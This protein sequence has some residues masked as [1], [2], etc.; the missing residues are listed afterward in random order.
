MATGVANKEII[1]IENTPEN[2]DTYCSHGSLA[3]LIPQIIKK[4]CYAAEQSDEP[5]TP[6]GWRAGGLVNRD[7]GRALEA[8]V[9]SEASMELQGRVH[10]IC[11]YDL[12]TCGAAFDSLRYVIDARQPPGEVPS[13]EIFQ[14]QHNFPPVLTW[15]MQKPR[16]AVREFTRD[17]Y[18]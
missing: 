6:E 12:V 5:A 8:I 13:V 18:A 1:E 17:V 15:Q 16:T 9:H 11:A 10:I 7:A 3:R 14:R 2:D 4:A